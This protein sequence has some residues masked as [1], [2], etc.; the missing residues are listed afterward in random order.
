MKGKS[1]QLSSRTPVQWT[2]EHHGVLHQLINTLTNPPVL[3]YPNFDLLF[4][5]H[6]DASQQGLGVV[7]Y[8]YPDGKLRVTPIVAEL[9]LQLRGTT[10]SILAILSTLL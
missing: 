1:A 7:L 8:Q 6:T 4:V 9:S 10:G 3:A 5:V 2:E